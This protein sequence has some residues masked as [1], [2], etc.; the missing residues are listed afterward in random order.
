MTHAR[1]NT[2][3][4]PAEPAP[5]DPARLPHMP[6]LD[7]L[8]GLAVIGVLLFHSGFDWATGGFLGVS[9]F[10]V[11]SGFLITSLLVREW[12]N[13]GSIR[14]GRFW[15][16]RFRR[17]LPA[18]LVSLALVALI[19]W[20]LGTAE[21]LANL[22]WDLLAALAYVANWRFYFDGTSYGELFSA[23][24]P[25]QHFWSLAIEEQY[26]LLFPPAL[27]ALMKAG[28]RRL[29]AAVLCA[30]TALSVGLGLWLGSDIDRIYYGTD[31]RA[32]ELLAGALLAM[33]WSQQQ[34]RTTG[35]K[36]PG[37]PAQA[38]SLPSDIAGIAALAAMFWSWWAITNTSQALSIGGLPLYAFLTTIIIHAA[39]RPGLV[40]QLLSWP[41]LRGIGLISYG[42]YLYHWPVFLILD[43][44]NPGWHPALLFALRMGITTALALASYHWLEMPIRRGQFLRSDRA[45]WGA[46]LSA[47]VAVAACAILVTLN[48]PRS[49]I[50]YA[51]VRLEDF[52]SVVT[53]SLDQES[54][55]NADPAASGGPNAGV[56]LILGD[57]GM[58]DAS[59]A[60][61]AVFEA[62]GASVVYERAYPGV[63]LSNP[64]LQWRA[65]YEKLIRRYKPEL[66]I[67]MLGGWD[68]PY[69]QKEGSAAYSRIVNQAA[70]ILT[71]RGAKLL[72]LSML[73]GGS[74][75]GSPINQV[76]RRLADRFPGKVAY[77]DIEASLRAPAGASSPETFEGAEAWPRAYV[78]SDGTPVILRKTDFWH[79]CP[80][81][82]ERL[83]RAINL[84][85]VELGWAEEAAPG[86]EQGDWR[87]DSRYTGTGAEYGCTVN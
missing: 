63:G 30:A 87:L 70:R 61:R 37:Q 76:Y 26:Y 44:K 25:V 38:G 79:L 58:V 48:P 10:F 15:A 36:T 24:S 68:T 80:T 39:V 57:S 86:W 13:R 83:A 67:M 17:L 62:A 43:G 66:V 7:G 51:D 2:R 82:A 53:D 6:G 85:A 60:L 72:W 65:S 18:A 28:G 78:D 9:T 46:A 64:K 22:R 21:Q 11:L 45:A 16:R 29:L 69:L 42:L 75:A 40:T 50:P 5:A 55:V 54:A 34:N 3:Q 35:G 19:W 32:A 77:A 59:P 4:L 23:P 52:S 1:I 74:T 31:T 27:I 33:W 49:A 47:A 56:V 81:G 14:L 71:A 41:P 84:A 20:Q 8:R 73:P 12:A